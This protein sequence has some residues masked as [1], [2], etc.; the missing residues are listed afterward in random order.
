MVALEQQ[1]HLLEYCRTALSDGQGRRENGVEGAQP[2]GAAGDAH[3]RKEA[4]VKGRE[5]AEKHRASRKQRLEEE[6][7]RNAK[8]VAQETC[9]VLGPALAR[10]LSP[11]RPG[12][13][14]GGELGSSTWVT[15]AKSHED[16]ARSE[17]E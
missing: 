6:V 5:R 7:K 12:I 2:G 17:A 10:I 9:S 11:Y 4:S 3:S 14:E 16:I 15:E 8:I 13:M 1:P